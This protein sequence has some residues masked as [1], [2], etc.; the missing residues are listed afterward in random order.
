MKTLIAIMI[1]AALGL[2]GCSTTPILMSQAQ[3]IPSHEKQNYIN[4]TPNSGHI[5]V[6]RDSGTAG[7][8]CMPD[9]Y[10]NGVLVANSLTEG[11]KLD[12]YPPAGNYILSTATFCGK[13]STPLAI[14]V[15]PNQIQIFDLG[16]RHGT[17]ILIPANN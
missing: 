4:P 5:V 3:E 11:G 7:S 14:T 2:A 10:L 1:L 16:L 9:V 17:F 8:A 6:V 15:V 12:F 13:G